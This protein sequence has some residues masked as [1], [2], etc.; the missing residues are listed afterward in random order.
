MALKPQGNNILAGTALA[1]AQVNSPAFV[2]GVSGW[3]IRQ[4]GS[5]E[6]NNVVIRG[7]EVIGG[8]QLIYSGTPAA[9]NLIYSVAASGGTDSV[10]NVY[11]AGETSYQNAGGGTYYALNVFNSQINWYSAT[12]EAG[13]WTAGSGIDG[14]ADVFNVGA[15]D[16]QLLLQ[17]N[18]FLVNNGTL[19]TLSGFQWTPSAGLVSLISGGA[20]TW[21]AI[22][23]ATGFTAGGQTPEYRLQPD[24]TV[25]LR[26]SVSL[27]ATHAADTVFWTLPTGYHPVVTQSFATPTSLSGYAAGNV[28]VKV[29]ASTAQI[30]VNGVSGNFVTLDDIVYTLDS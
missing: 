29:T 23:P 13:P 1:I 21:H 10:G 3:I 8:T 15:Q 6:F 11:L 28:V 20:E 12:S 24:N 25:R 19:V 16:M 27:T 4:D 22:T 30:G 26:G 9:N 2:T 7:G 18:L 17:E 14:R 5:A